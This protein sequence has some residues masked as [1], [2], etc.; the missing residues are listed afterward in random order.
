MQGFRMRR[1]SLYVWTGFGNVGGG[2]G[3]MGAGGVHTST[4]VERMWKDVRDA[5]R[6]FGACSRSP[7]TCR[8]GAF[9][10]CG[11]LFRIAQDDVLILRTARNRAGTGVDDCDGL[12]CAGGPYSLGIFTF[13]PTV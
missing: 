4:G 12:Q 7:S 2:S 5:Q 8:R 13:D 9:A 6:A 11:G 10:C 1:R 3:N